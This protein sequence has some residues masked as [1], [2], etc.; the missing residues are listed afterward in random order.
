YLIYIIYTGTQKFANYFN[1][2]FEIIILIVVVNIVYKQLNPSY[3]IAWIVFIMFLPIPGILV[4]L[5][6]GNNKLP[7]VIQKKLNSF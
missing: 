2:I 4:Y 7:K 1:T 6:W 5:L 3:K